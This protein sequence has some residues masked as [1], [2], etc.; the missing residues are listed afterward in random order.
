VRIAFVDESGDIGSKG[1][2]TRHFVLVALV[3]EHE[4][5]STVNA[6]LRAMRE[7]L[8]S[9]LGLRL[10]A[11]IHAS[12]FLGG[13]E[14]HLGLGVRSRF[15]A[16]HHMVRTLEKIP[17][18]RAA[19]F[20]VRKEE[21][22]HAV[23]DT[24]WKGLLRKVAEQPRAGMPTPC[25]SRGLLIICDHHSRL[26]Y[27][28]SQAMLDELAAA[29]ELLELPFGRDSADSLILQAADLLAYLAKQIIEPNSH[30]S[31]GR[32]RN[33]LQRCE[34]LFTGSGP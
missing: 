24:A 20:A 2:P 15:L 8:R 6:E 25:P 4:A 16:A 5:W 3:V 11:E 13:S 33:L 18:V 26:P 21:I 22:A 10:D 27:R 17:G 14:S 9:S 32:G 30:F 1:S 23:L 28:P 34:R 19:R 12:E 31:K 29:E 7:R